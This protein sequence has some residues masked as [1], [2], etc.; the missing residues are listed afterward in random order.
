[1]KTPFAAVLLASSWLCAPAAHAVIVTGL[2]EA[3]VPVADQST[4]ERNNSLQQAF[5]V[6]LVKVTGNRAAA[7]AL[8][9][10]LGNP[11][12]YVQQYRY[13]KAAV[14]PA[15]PNAVPSL[16]LWAQFDPGVVKRALHGVHAPLWGAERPRTVVWLALPERI[17]AAGDSSPLMQAMQTAAEQRGIVL[18]FPQMDSTDK[19]ALAAADLAGFNDERIRAASGRY[20]AD[21]ILAGRV[22]PAEGQ[23]AAR[24]QWLS[25]DKVEDWQSPAG[26]Q[27]LLAVDGVQVAA[28]RFAARYAV[29]PDAADQDGIALQVD[30]VSS[31]DAYARVL[32]YLNSLTP[33]R[34]VHLQRVAGGSVYYT[35][36]IHGSV[37]NFES[38]LVLGGSLTAAPGSAAEGA[39]AAGTAQ[40]PAAIPT[41]AL[42]YSYNPG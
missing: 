31:L 41:A 37:D 6:V 10:E 39:P 14:D 1:M 27:T 20:H 28:D 5:D 25:P 42:R 7:G 12:Q 9:A 22:A 4:A 33:V 36:D 18:V 17:L 21:A 38:A 19:A 11:T 16:L 26:D 34:A 40:A 24:W 8:A 29:S 23:F 2:Y 32:A 13:E 3:R 15:T 35:V 30:G